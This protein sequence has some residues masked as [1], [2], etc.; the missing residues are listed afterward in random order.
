MITYSRGAAT[1]TPFVLMDSTASDNY[2]VGVRKRCAF[3]YELS[4]LENVWG[5]GDTEAE[6]IGDLDR[7]IAQ[8]R[9]ALERVW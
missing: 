1:M 3:H 5:D 7:K 4:G 9:A 8:I 6:A 2:F